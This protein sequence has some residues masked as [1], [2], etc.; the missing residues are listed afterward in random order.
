MTK[1]YIFIKMQNYSK[2]IKKKRENIYIIILR[3][4]FL[5][6]KKKN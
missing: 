1:N 5:K 3:R 6:S 2:Y 4:K